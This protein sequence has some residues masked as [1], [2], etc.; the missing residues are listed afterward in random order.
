MQ[1]RPR[2]RALRH[3]GEGLDRPAPKFTLVFEG[4]LGHLSPLAEPEFAGLMKDRD[5][6]R[7]VGLW[8]L[9]DLVIRI[10]WDRVWRYGQTWYVV[11]Y[12]TADASFAAA[13]HARLD[14]EEIPVKP[15]CWA[16]EAGAFARRLITMPDI[17]RV[18]DPD[19]GRVGIYS[20]AIGRLLTDPRQL[21][22]I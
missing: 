3:K 8:E 4:A 2:Q 20:P 6:T 17:I 7:A 18:Y 14:A 22:V 9:S 15:P 5:Y 11:T 10:L 21:G 19:P 12:L 16:M 1:S 13:L